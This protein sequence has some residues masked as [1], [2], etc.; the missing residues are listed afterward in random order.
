MFYNCNYEVLNRN[1]E[2]ILDLAMNYCDSF[3]YVVRQDCVDL[4]NIQTKLYVFSDYLI[5]KQ[6]M[7]SWPGT[8]LL[9]GKAIVFKYHFSI[10]SLK[11]LK[12]VA[13]EF[14]TWIHPNYPE[15]LCFIRENDEEFLTTITHENDAYFNLIESEYDYVTRI[16]P[17]LFIE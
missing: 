4:T 12:H 5:E 17:D 2:L 14:N 11:K 7:V 10:E 13:R 8:I 16:V 6:E 3:L 1:Y 9:D 15:D